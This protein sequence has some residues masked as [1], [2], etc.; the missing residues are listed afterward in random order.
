MRNQ[1][2][3]TQGLFASGKANIARVQNL[4]C[5]LAGYAYIARFEVVLDAI[6]KDGYLLRAEYP[7]SK[8]NRTALKIGT[9]AISQVLR[10]PHEAISDLQTDSNA[11]RRIA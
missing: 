1:V 11:V 4:R 2:N 10:S 5:R 6:E 9:A 7:E 3:E 8:S